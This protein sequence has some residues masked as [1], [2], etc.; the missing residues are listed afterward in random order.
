[1]K[2][3][4]AMPVVDMRGFRWRLAALERGREHALEGARLALAHC[5]QQ[6]HAAEAAAQQRRERQRAQE[7]V[8][9]HLAQQDVHA[10]A[11]AARYLAQLEAARLAAEGSRLEL[12]QRLLA[13][14][15]ACAERQRQLECLQ[16]M[17]T[18]ARRQHAQA[19]LSRE[20]KEAD[21]AALVIAQ[22]RRAARS[23]PGREVP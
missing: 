16:S 6:S 9:L 20:W 3:P 10:G 14:R 11:R 7:E 17:R 15:A 12:E 18:A 22:Q 5:Q 4:Q 13:A 2:H 1:M 8:A 19:Q 21:A 23:R